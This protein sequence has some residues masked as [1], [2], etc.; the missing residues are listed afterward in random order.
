MIGKI[1]RLYKDKGFGY[2][3]C[4]GNEYY[5]TINGLKNTTFEQIGRAHV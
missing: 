2:I 5:F 3:L 1:L 4:G